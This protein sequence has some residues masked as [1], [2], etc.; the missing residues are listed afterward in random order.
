MRALDYHSPRTSRR[1]GWLAARLF[2]WHAWTAVALWLAFSGLT[3]LLVLSGL[4]R[5]TERPR[6]VIA[7][8]A[9]TA[10]GPMTGAVSRDFQSCCV[11][12]SVSLLPYCLVGLLAGLAVQLIVPARGPASGAVRAV[13]WI[14]GWGIWFG[15]GIVSFG[16]AL[17]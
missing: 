9:A 7:T 12:F 1:T 14:A 6:T 16:H 5:A 13:S 15:G 2:R 3:L 8:T 11:N 4:D 17:F 10:L